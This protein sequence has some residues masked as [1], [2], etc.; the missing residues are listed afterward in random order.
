[1]FTGEFVCSGV[2]SIDPRGLEGGHGCGG[3][4]EWEGEEH[5]SIIERSRPAWFHN[6]LLRL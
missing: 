1:M 4:W 3:G 6:E 2:A 5:T